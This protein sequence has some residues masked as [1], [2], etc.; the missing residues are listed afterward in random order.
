MTSLYAFLVSTIKHKI[1]NADFGRLIGTKTVCGMKSCYRFVGA[2]ALFLL[3]ACNSKQVDYLPFQETEDG[4]WGLMDRKGKVLFADEFEN[5]IWGISE[6]VLRTTDDKGRFQFYTVA[7]KPKLICEG[8]EDAGDFTGGFAPIVMKNEWIKFINKKGK[9]ISELKEINGLQVESVSPFHF[10]VAI[11]RLEDG[12]AGLIDIKG[13]VLTSPKRV[14]I[15]F[16][17]KA[18]FLSSAVVENEN[19]LIEYSDAVLLIHYKDFINGKN[20]RALYRLDEEKHTPY[21]YKNSHYYCIDT[22]KKHIIMDGSKDILTIDRDSKNSYIYDIMGKHMLFSNENGDKMGVMDM[23]GNVVIRPK[24]SFLTFMD[25]KTL[26]CSTKRD[27]F[28]IINIKDDIISSNVDIHE[29]VYEGISDFL[30]YDGIALFV[31][32]NEDY[33][34]A[35]KK[36]EPVNNKTYHMIESEVSH[37]SSGVTSDFFNVNKLIGQLNITEHGIG[38]VSIN[39]TVD[40]FVEYDNK[41]SYYEVDINDYVYEDEL[42]FYEYYDGIK[43]EFYPSF[44]GY[45]AMNAASE[46]GGRSVWNRDCKLDKLLAGFYL[47]E[48]LEDRGDAIYEGLCEF[49]VAKSIKNVKGECKASFR[50]KNSKDLRLAYDKEKGTMVLIYCNFT[51]SDESFYSVNE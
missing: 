39:N 26:L 24:Y 30:L 51:M 42:G 34:F 10:G 16:C 12:S 21:F 32:E 25:E 15:N 17:T 49:F 43:V 2:L 27:E 41:D 18:N 23:K 9:V 28:K 46:H 50:F 3:V 44:D 33:Y 7:K 4:N 5:P 36:G 29:D 31:D 20:N 13:T 6:G 22:K 11:Y 1:I 38:G 35:N 14:G 48:E 19:L 47:T 40:E 37:E 45:I 8:Y